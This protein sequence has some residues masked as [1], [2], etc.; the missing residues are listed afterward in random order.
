MCTAFI[1]TWWACNRLDAVFMDNGL[2]VP[3]WASWYR[4]RSTNGR[5]VSSCGCSNVHWPRCCQL[6]R[7]F[8]NQPFSFKSSRS[9]G[10]KF[11][12]IHKVWDSYDVLCLR[13][14]NSNLVSELKNIV[15]T[16]KRSLKT[17]WCSLSIRDSP[18]RVSWTRSGV[19]TKDRRERI[20]HRQRE[21]R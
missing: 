21:S 16:I 18:A 1:Y 17:V 7:V 10:T 6:E 5:H 4:P 11:T 8:V 19:A 15:H 9:V 12:R 20:C 2:W 13:T 14:N 3:R